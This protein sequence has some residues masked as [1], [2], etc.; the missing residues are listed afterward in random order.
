MSNI[1]IINEIEMLRNMISGATDPK[2]IEM[3]E[4]EL[5]CAI[6]YMEKM[7]SKGR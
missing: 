4:M 5:A 1:S 7:V 2:D 6:G 3:L